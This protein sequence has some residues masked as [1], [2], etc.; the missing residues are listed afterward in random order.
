MSEPTPPIEH[1]LIRN[2]TLFDDLEILD[3]K[4]CTRG[5]SC[6][7]NR[8]CAATAVCGPA[9]IRRDPRPLPGNGDALRR[10]PLAAEERA[11]V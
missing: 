4:I 5:S 7:T 6:P 3:P 11:E 2:G 8:W 9:G 1:D 10:S